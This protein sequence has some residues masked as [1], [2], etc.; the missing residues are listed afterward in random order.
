MLPRPS[1]LQLTLC[2]G[3]INLLQWVPLPSRELR[4]YKW[5]Q[6]CKVCM[7][8]ELQFVTAPGL[9]KGAD[10]RVRL[11]SS[12]VRTSVLRC[13]KRVIGG[14]GPQ[15]KRQGHNFGEVH[16]QELCTI[17]FALRSP[18]HMCYTL[19]SI[20]QYLWIDWCISPVH[21]SRKCTSLFTNIETNPNQ[22]PLLRYQNYTMQ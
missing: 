18:Q 9:R 5:G 12:R 7:R 2:A 20:S 19:Q 4:Q 16:M 15:R 21:Y 13:H 8:Q 1:K 11:H 3:I 22:S 14:L 17:L 6:A 10:L